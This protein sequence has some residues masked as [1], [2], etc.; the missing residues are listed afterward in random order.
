MIANQVVRTLRVAFARWRFF[1]YEVER[2]REVGDASEAELAHLSEQADYWYLET[3]RS[4]GMEKHDL[5]SVHP[6]HL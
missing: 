6:G 4:E 2:R 3:K 5:W 1:A